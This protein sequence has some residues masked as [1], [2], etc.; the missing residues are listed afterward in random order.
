MENENIVDAEA[1]SYQNAHLVVSPIALEHLN[2]TGK[3]GKFLAIVGFC[4]IGLAIIGGLFAGTIF[5][6][7][8]SSNADMP[9]PGFLIGVIYI[10]MGLL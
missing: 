7:M 4:F 2:E 3:W 1:S 8:G 6:M 5:S 10:V 9:F